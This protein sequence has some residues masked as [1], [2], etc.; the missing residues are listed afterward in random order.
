MN[1]KPIKSRTCYE[2]HE[3]GH[4]AKDCPTLDS[5][6]HSSSNG[7]SL[8]LIIH[9]CLMA[10]GSKVTPTLNP[11]ISPN[12]ESDDDADGEDVDGKDD[13]NNAFLHGMGIVYASLRGN[14]NACVKIEYLMDTVFKHKETIKELNSLVNEVKR[15]FNLLKQELLE[16]KHTN[17]SL[18]QTIETYKLEKTKSINDTCATNS[19]SCEAYI[20]K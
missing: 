3:Y 17:A 7:E 18:S 2:C 4:I 16:E 10:R 15:R 13:D 5:E 11:N 1:K 14:N 9:M 19:T 6:V 8:T 20:L 12:D